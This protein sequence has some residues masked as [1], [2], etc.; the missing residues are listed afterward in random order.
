MTTDNKGFEIAHD[1]RRH[2][3]RIRLWGLWD[4]EL[5][6]KCKYAMQEKIEDIVKDGAHW[7][8]LVDLTG[9]YPRSKAVQAMIREHL[10]TARSQGMCRI[11][12]LGNHSILR[13]RLDRI[14]PKNTSDAEAFGKTESEALQWLL[15][16]GEHEHAGITEY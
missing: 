16:Q 7:Y 10:D 5:A 6:Q 4:V 13:K 14:F 9:F 12:Y 3:L 1:I 11:A 2:I 15:Q 8:A